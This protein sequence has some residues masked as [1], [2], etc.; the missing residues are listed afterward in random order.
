MAKFTHILLDLDGTLT[1][2]EEGITRSVAC[3]LDSLSMPYASIG[4]LKTFI[5]PPLVQ[6]FAEYGVKE[7]DMDKAITKFREYYAN[8]GIF[9]CTMFK[10]VPD[11]LTTLK[12]HDKKIFLAT[13]KVREYAHRVLDYFEITRYFDFISGSELDG[14]RTVKADVIAYALKETNTKV[15]SAVVMVGD[16]KHD[17]IGAKKNNITAVG[18]LYGF[19]SEKEFKTE[20]AGY[21][22][23][24]MEDLKNF[25]IQ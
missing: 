4:A 5:G 6:S 17:I 11:L 22:L 20:N 13:S 3:A 8:Q 16:R 23:D 7:A 2:P 12:A 9:E 15:T 1:D 14:S 21:I 18:I 19:G 10:G 25:L 24:S